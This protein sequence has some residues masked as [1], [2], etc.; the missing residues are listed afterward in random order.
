VLG[1]AWGTVAVVVLLAFGVG[2]ERQTKKRFHGL[3]DRIVI[4]FGGRTTKAF[5]G[6]PNGRDI[7]IT[8]ADATLLG[9]EVAE[10][11]QISPEYI[12]RSKVRR[13]VKAANPA[14]TGILPVYGEMRNIIP[15]AGGRWLNQQDVDDRRRVAVLGDELATLLFEDKSPI[16]EQ[17]YLG[18][19]PFIVIG[20]MNPS[21]RTH[22]TS[23]GT[24]TGSSSPPARTSRCTAGASSTTS[25][26][27]RGA[28]ATKVAEKRVYETL[29][30]KY[31]F[32]PPMRM[33]WGMGHQRVGDAVRGDVHRLQRLLRSWEPSR[34]W[35]AGS[36]SRTSCTSWYANVPAR[37]AFAAPSGPPAVTSS[38]SSSWR[39]A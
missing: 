11:D 38:S 4:L 22:R 15:Q 32:D 27:G 29:G 25:C 17:V 23:S 16:G 26:T 21:C 9:H 37:S 10:I 28:R 20:V 36:A 39:P 13:G 3:G 19:T 6:F 31:R 1:I 14:V 34:C 12:A 18:D 24:R 2:L 35:W 33:R 30:R 7:S 5:A 8:E